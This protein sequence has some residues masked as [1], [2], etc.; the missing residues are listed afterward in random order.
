MNVS[1]PYSVNFAFFGINFNLSKFSYLISL[2]IIHQTFN[3]LCMIG[4]NPSHD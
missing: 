1:D 3:C 2:V 4:L